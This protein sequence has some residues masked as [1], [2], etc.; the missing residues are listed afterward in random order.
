[1]KKTIS[2]FLVIIM[3]VSI[4]TIIPISTGAA[5]SNSLYCNTALLQQVGKQIPKLPA[6]ACY[7]LAYSRTMLDDTVHYFHEYNKNGYDESQAWCIWSWGGYSVVSGGC[8]ED[9]FRACYDS[10]NNNRPIIIHVS[11]SNGQHWVTVVGYQNVTSIDSMTESNLLIIDPGNGYL[12][13]P[14]TLSN[15]TIHSDYGYRITYTGSVPN[16]HNDIPYPVTN[17]YSDRRIYNSSESITIKWEPAVGTYNYWIYL[18]KDGKELYS[19]DCGTNLSFTSAPTSAGSYTFIIRPGNNYGFNDNSV[20]YKFIVTDDVPQPVTTLT[21]E[22]TVYTSSEYINFTW[23]SVYDADNYWVYLWRDGK[24]LYSYDCGNKTYFK[25][26]PTSPGNYTLIIRPGNINGYNNNSIAYDFVVSNGYTITYNANGGTGVPD[27]QFKDYGKEITLSNIIPSREGYV[28]KGWGASETSTE[29]L[30][31]P[32]SIYN[33]NKTITLYAVWDEE[34]IISYSL[35]DVDLDGTISIIDA[36]FIQ[37][38]L[39]QFSSL[40]SIQK[41]NADTHKDGQISILDATQI[42]RFLA[43]VISQF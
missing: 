16:A 19:Y 22:K 20:N 33:E 6:C 1:M 17:I 32:G 8:R 27:S 37:L 15:Y 21:S 39:A 40:T 7:A 42:Q 23:E 12:G 34:E 24:E 2:F 14:E 41:I 18:W 28:F 26:A 36:T 29:V 4:F 30:Y 10:I 3:V 25:S 31:H 11:G 38:Y 13:Y 5:T 43:Q 35:G 9:V